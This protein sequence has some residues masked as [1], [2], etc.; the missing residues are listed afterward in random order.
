MSAVLLIAVV[1]LVVV[2]DVIVEGYEV[3]PPV[4]VPLAPDRGRPAVGRPSAGASLMATFERTG[5]LRLERQ[6][7]GSASQTVD[8][9]VAACVMALDDAFYG[10]IRPST[11][12]LRKRMG[13]DLGATNPDQWKAAIDA[14]A[15]RF[16]SFGLQPP[17]TAVVRS[18]GHDE[19]WRLHHDQR[20]RVIAALHYGT[21]A[22]EKRSLW[23]S[24]S[25]RGNH[26]VYLRAATLVNEGR[27]V[28]AYDPLADGR[29]TG[30]PN[31]RRLWPYWLV[32]AATGNVR[33]AKGRRLYPAED[34]WIGLVVAKARP[35][36]EPGE[37]V[38]PG[39]PDGGDP[40]LP[41]VTELLEAI[42]D[43]AGE[44]EDHIAAMT[45]SLHGLRPYLPAAK[46]SDA[47]PADGV[48]A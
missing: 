22:S 45:A 2:L 17:R 21:V 42:A 44:L 20:R 6:L 48:A 10:H 34:R 18:K 47:E 19:L 36:G 7:D 37:G 27:R 1:V 8:C 40:D 29:F 3:S 24:R 23:A 33:D 26:A 46:S 43:T 14:Y 16:A 41:D 9:G 5:P 38:D 11:E 15:D 25:F 30:C 28:P 32:K 12:A 35:I 13:N 31:G 39:D 4:L